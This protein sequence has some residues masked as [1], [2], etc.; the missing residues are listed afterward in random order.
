MS[1]L[2]YDEAVTLSL[3]RLFVSLR[4]GLQKLHCTRC[5]SVPKHEGL[6]PGSYSITSQINKM[7]HGFDDLTT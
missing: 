7:S 4:S 6:C 5:S 2:F 1:V 3:R